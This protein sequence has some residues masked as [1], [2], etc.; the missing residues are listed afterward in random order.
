[1]NTGLASLARVAGSALIVAWCLALAFAPANALT[2]DPRPDDASI[3]VAHMFEPVTLAVDLRLVIRR[4]EFDLRDAGD[5]PTPLHLR[6]TWYVSLGA[7]TLPHAV[8]LAISPVHS[9]RNVEMRVDGVP[10]ELMAESEADTAARLYRGSFPLAP[11]VEQR[12]DVEYDLA[13]TRTSRTP[14]ELAVDC[15]LAFD[16]TSGHVQEVA[17]TFHCARPTPLPALAARPVPY[18]YAPDSLSWRLGNVRPETR[19]SIAYAPRVAAQFADRYLAPLVVRNLD[20]PWDH[21]LISFPA[22]VSE[23]SLESAWRSDSTSTERTIEQLQDAAREANWVRRMITDGRADRLLTPIEKLNVGYCRALVDA[24]HDQRDP[25]K[26]RDALAALR[27]RY[28]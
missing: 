4:A 10:V 25:K 20:Y 21:S 11:G 12:L 5:G 13:W 17:I 26:M 2:D 15:P 8:T 6:S 24:I 18:Q 1:V 3:A 16:S 9:A 27:E 7:D 19:F 23:A 22:A 14:Y 28:W